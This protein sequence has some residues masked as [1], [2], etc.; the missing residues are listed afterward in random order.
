MR[1]GKA[2]YA[3]LSNYSAAQTREAIRICRERG[4]VEPVIHQPRH[5]L[6][7]RR[8]E[9]DGLFE[10]LAELGLG[11]VCFSPL[12]GGL[13]SGKYLDGVPGDTR[14]GTQG[15]TWLDPWISGDKRDRI[16]ALRDLAKTQNL[17]PT[18]LSLLWTL[19]AGRCPSALIGASRPSQIEEACALLQH[20]PLPAESL[21]TLD[22]LFPLSEA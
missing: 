7:D 6:I 12:Q 16:A 2:L 21:I 4:Y 1:S 15:A 22:V 11:S 20:G 18:Q 8:N 9:R 10:T 3:G 5:N 13:L 19:R 14:I 17:T